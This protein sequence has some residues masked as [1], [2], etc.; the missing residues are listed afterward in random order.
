MGRRWSMEQ[1]ANPSALRVHVEHQLT[2]RTIETSPPATI[3]R[4]LAGLLELD[5]VRTLDLH[6]YHARINL[7]HGADRDAAA[8]HVRDILRA[9]WGVETEGNAESDP[10]AF[11]ID[12]AGP[13]VVAESAE[14]AAGRELLVRLF[15]VSGVR[16][17]ILGDG[18][19]LV[20]IGRLFTWTAVE[21]AVTAALRA[22]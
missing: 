7:R 22:P 16:E 8:G 14:M 4:S 5:A 21:P 20:R 1:P 11:E 6:R 10:R 15:T 18:L 3:A 17:A 2:D 19:A 9:A 12:Y 13:R